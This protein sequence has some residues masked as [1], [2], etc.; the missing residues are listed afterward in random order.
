[1]RA[2]GLML[3]L[4]AG[5]AAPASA[6]TLRIGIQEDPEAMDP[7]V[8]TSFVGRVIYAGLCDKL[9]DVAPDLSFVPQLAT[10]WSWS[11][12]ARALTLTLR[13][14]VVFHDG[15]AFDAAAVK[16]NIERYKTTPGSMRKGELAPVQAVE[17]VDP[18]TVRIQLSEPY[19]PLLAV[20]A[21]RS[22]MMVSPKAMADPQFAQHPVCAGPFAWVERR[23]NERIVLKRFDRY[24]DPDAVKLDEIDYLPIADPSV[25]LVNLQSGALDIVERL[26]P[27]DVA[28]ARA[29]SRLRVLE[30][31]A[32][33][34]YLVSINLNHG[35]RSETPLGR[36]LRVRE[37]LE[38]AIDR[39][40]LNQV[41]FDGR[42]APT[43][44][45]QAV[46][47][48]YYDAARPMPQRDVAKAKALLAAAG[49]P[50][51]AFT[52]SV[53]NTPTGLQVAQVLQSMV[54]EAGFDMK[55]EA[56][57]PVTVT[58]NAEKG[59]YEMAFAIWSGRV[60]PDQNLSMWAACNG[61]LNWGRYCDPEVDAAL[62]QARV[63][64]DPAERARHYADAAERYLDARPQ[65]YLY[66]FSWIWAVSAKLRGFVPYPDGLIRL[67]GVAL[68]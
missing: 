25:R 64:T 14:D 22:G 27:T 65:L 66:N 55:I 16:A 63:V 56:M 35:P 32:L 4:A 61:F 9:I 53:G 67:R 54:A 12:D 41:V 31:T 10:G 11:A 37:A 34:Y 5:L 42:F 24:W 15:T 30:T 58:A 57:E 17:V 19:A 51:V 28:K 44:Q 26:N 62:R 1:M 8:G 2:I 33:G 38:L 49:H 46:G 43:N 29:D 6:A 36:D 7:M 60:D 21:D 59:D 50:H 3:L 45:P 52:F 68:P 39:N 47:S 18:R 40:A 13:P 23:A 20:L 48:P